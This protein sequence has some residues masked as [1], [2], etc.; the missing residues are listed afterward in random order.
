MMLIN[1]VNNYINNNFV[2]WSF[3]CNFVNAKNC[4]DESSCIE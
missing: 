3:F 2:E 1:I 4:F